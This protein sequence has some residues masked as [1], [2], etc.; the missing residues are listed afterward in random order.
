MKT[1]GII[2]GFG[3][4]A[5]AQFY[6]GLT[7]KTRTN[8]LVRHVFVPRKLEHDAL[9]SGNNLD[10]F[11]PLLV[12]AAMELEKN[13]ADIIVLPCNTLHIH[14]DAIRSALGIPFISIIEETARFL[15]KQNISK[16]GFLGTRVTIRENLFKKRA[17]GTTFITIPSSV[18]RRIDF[19]LDQF[20][21]EQKDKNFICE[22]NNSI[23]TV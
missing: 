4:E 8:I 2:G 9:I 17:N 21:G 18:Q 7:A 11:K 6:M 23:Q 3:P 19:G 15:H 5:T 20:V 10:A 13:G 16:I 14:E 1:V 12:S 22:Q